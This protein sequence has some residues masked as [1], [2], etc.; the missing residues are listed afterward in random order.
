M[1]PDKDA[2]TQ[3][4]TISR[5]LT[6]AGVV[7]GTVAYMSPEQAR[8]DE[9]DHRSDI[10]SFGVLLYEL[11][12]G[13]FPFEGKTAIETLSA[14]LSYDPPP[15][16]DLVDEVPGE[17]GRIVS[18]ALEKEPQ[19]RYQTADDMVTDFRNLKRDLGTGRVSIPGRDTGTGAD[20]RRR[21]DAGARSHG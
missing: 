5:E 13:R 10:F 14:T 18:K 4:E 8:G 11:A 7:L 21:N 16:S 1:K 3:L 15:V 17:A 6:L 9:V 19:R 2:T 20:R 12:T